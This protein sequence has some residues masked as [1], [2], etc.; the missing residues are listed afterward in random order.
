MNDIVAR[1]DRAAELLIHT[2][3]W[4]LSDRAEVLGHCDRD[5][6]QA[7][8]ARV[9]RKTWLLIPGT[10]ARLAQNGHS[11]LVGDWWRNALSL[12]RVAVEFAV[13]PPVTGASGRYSWA[14]GFLEAANIVDDWLLTHWMGLP[15]DYCAGHSQGA[16]VAQI[17]SW[18]R[19]WRGSPLSP[20]ETHAIAAP[21][22]TYS[23]DAPCC[24]RVHC[25]IAPDDPVCRLPL[26]ASHVGRVYTL[27][28]WPGS[29]GERH[30]LPGYRARL[31]L[32]HRSM[33]AWTRILAKD[34]REPT[35]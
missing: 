24:E 10:G 14:W 21:R 18:S 35:P 17:L 16:A 13:K 27:P 8:L 23:S 32:L 15:I 28:H 7:F 1:A 3:A 33:P 20:G 2:Y 4:R 19:W 5:G 25:W 12:A 26:G 34:K 9:D 29:L 11:E 31:D 30:R 22:V 6:V